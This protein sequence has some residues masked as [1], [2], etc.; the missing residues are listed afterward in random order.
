MEDRPVT[1]NLR[2]TSTTAD[3]KETEEVVMRAGDDLTA[4]QRFSTV[5]TV[6]L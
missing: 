2:P 4:Q 1:A 5:L 6:L 3:A